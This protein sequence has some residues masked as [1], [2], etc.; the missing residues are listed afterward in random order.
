[1]GTPQ[2][3]AGGESSHTTGDTGRQSF[4][5][6][7]DGHVSGNLTRD[8]ELRFTTTGKPLASIRVAD[9]PRVYDQ[10]SGEWMDGPTVYQDV[11]IWGPMGER[12]AERLVKGDR[13]CATGRWQ[14]RSWTDAE[15]LTQSRKSLIAR[16]IGPSL[17]ARDVSIIRGGK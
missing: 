8:P 2:P 1:M 13:I 15:G 6:L 3:P 11:T 10:G 17:L 9:T 16:D 12:V 7:G 4:T 14:Q 5:D